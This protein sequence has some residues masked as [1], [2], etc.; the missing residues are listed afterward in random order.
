MGHGLIG[1]TAGKSETITIQV[2]LLSPGPAHARLCSSW[3]CNRVRGQPHVHRR[4]CYPF[5]ER[6]TAGLPDSSEHCLKVA[7]TPP[8][9]SAMYMSELVRFC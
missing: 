4:S 1:G 7:S 5:S 3:C 9:A 6:F 8:H 2:R